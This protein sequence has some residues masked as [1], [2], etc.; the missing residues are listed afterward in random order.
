MVDKQ[1]FLTLKWSA[2]AA[3][4]A[5]LFAVG[6]G[7]ATALI[8]DK[9]PVIR[10]PMDGAIPYRSAALAFLGALGVAWAFAL[11]ATAVMRFS[12]L[13]QGPEGPRFATS[14]M[15]VG[16]V[17]LPLYGLG[18]L[19]LIPGLLMLALGT[20]KV[21]WLSG[22]AISLMVMGGLA[23]IPAVLL[24]NVDKQ[25]RAVLILPIGLVGAG[26]VLLGLRA[27]PQNA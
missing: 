25:W 8:R 20:Q 27:S 22:M 21:P 5:W 26:W 2:I 16:L 7:V 6:V 15:L 11:V 18:L 24:D 23:Y 19:A 17:L 10:D 13:K 1:D 14:L 3:G 4:A 9:G 12:L